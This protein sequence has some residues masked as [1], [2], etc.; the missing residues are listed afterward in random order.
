LTSADDEGNY[1][2]RIKQINLDGTFEYS[3]EQE[4]IVSL[5]NKFNLN[6]NYPNPFNPS[7]EISY[8]LPHAA[9]VELSI[10]DITGR[11]VKTLVKENQPVGRKKVNWNGRDNNNIEV[12]SG[13]YFYQLKAGEISLVR[14]MLLLR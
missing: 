6:Q 14:R 5:P 4:V 9:I 13:L 8:F 2:Y 12:A 3:T 10:Y 1:H 11:H 7:T